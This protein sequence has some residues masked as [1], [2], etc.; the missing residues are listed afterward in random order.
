MHGDLRLVG[1]ANNSEG[2]IE[3]CFDGM[4]GSICDNFWTQSDADIA[5]KQ[6]GFAAAG[7]CSMYK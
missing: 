1:G 7:E 2:R 4:W 3:V 5:C 6:L